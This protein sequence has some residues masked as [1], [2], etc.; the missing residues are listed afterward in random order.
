MSIQWASFTPDGKRV[1]IS[2]IESG[3]GPRTYVFDMASGKPRP[4]SPEG[5][6]A[7]PGHAISPDGSRIAAPAPDGSIAL[8]PLD[9]GEARPLP[10]ALPNDVPLRWTRDGIFVYRPDLP[11]RLDILDAATGARRTWKEVI[12]PDPA[13]V[14]Q[15]EPFVMS[16]DGS[17][18]LYSYR[19][20]I[21]D[22][23][24]MTGVR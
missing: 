8:Y 18:Y 16:E 24:L 13:G 15:I 7:A 17:I 22:L 6:Q 11:G 14:L 9:G 10:G 2:G 3:H 21:D 4:I 23:E 5:V 20:I 19:R 1:V 12:P